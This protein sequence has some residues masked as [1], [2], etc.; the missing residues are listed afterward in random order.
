MNHIQKMEEN[1]LIERFCF[2]EFQAEADALAEI[3]ERI[4]TR[5]FLL[6]INRTSPIVDEAGRDYI[7][8]VIKQDHGFG[9]RDNRSN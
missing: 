6:F 3:H 7:Y 8:R 4:G 5:D 2:L 1:E 9:F